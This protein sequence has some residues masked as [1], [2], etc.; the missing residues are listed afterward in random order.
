MVVVLAAAGV[1]TQ[2]FHHEKIVRRKE[3]EMSGNGRGEAPFHD[4]AALTLCS[5]FGC[6]SCLSNIR[7]YNPPA[8]LPAIRNRCSESDSQ[9]VQFSRTEFTKHHH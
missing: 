5:S 4:V 1:H 9:N 2:V 7:H 8:S 3:M 6:V